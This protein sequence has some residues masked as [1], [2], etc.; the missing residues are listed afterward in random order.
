MQR[1]FQPTMAVLMLAVT[2]TV[3]PGIAS[4]DVI[5]VGDLNI[6]QQAGNTSDGLRFLD[7]SFSVGLNQAGALAN[8]QANYSNARLATPSEW[9]DLFAAA[10]I[11]YDGAL[12]ASDAF[13]VGA[14]ADISTGSNYDDGILMNQLGITSQSADGNGALWSEVSAIWS[15]PTGDSQ[16]S[17][18]RDY[19]ILHHYF[20]YQPWAQPESYHAAIEQHSNSGEHST[21]GW[22]IVS[23]ATTAVPEPSSI[24]MF[25]IGALGLFGY[26]RRRRQTSAAA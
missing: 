4:A 26:S 3:A 10:G 11:A 20:E 18:T 23:D 17:T 24:A 7:L 21:F 6:I 16:D 5:E 12:T 8:A 1:S 19:V 14:N 2:M 25:G 9:D 13:T 15:D 22:M